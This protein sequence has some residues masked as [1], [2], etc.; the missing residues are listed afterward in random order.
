[1]PKSSE[2]H[3]GQRPPAKPGFER[4]SAESAVPFDGAIEGMALPYCRILP[5]SAL[6]RMEEGVCLA[7]FGVVMRACNRF[8]QTAPPVPAHRGRVSVLRECMHV[9]PFKVLSDRQ[10]TCNL[11]HKLQVKL[12]VLTVHSDCRQAHHC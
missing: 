11:L 6:L 9:T 12:D 10:Q 2:C 5:L 7:R 3:V 1:M 4:Q 8:V